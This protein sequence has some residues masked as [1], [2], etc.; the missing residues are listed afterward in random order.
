[1][2]ALEFEKEKQ[3]RLWQGQDS[4][5]RELDAR[6]STQADT[7][8]NCTAPFFHLRSRSLPLLSTNSV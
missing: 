8:E 2:D 1:M 3:Q 4:W 6:H 7:H 5:R